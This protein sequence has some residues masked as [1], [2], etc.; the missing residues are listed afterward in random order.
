MTLIVNGEKQ[1]I[2]S[3]VENIIDLL[4]HNDV[5]SPDMVTVQLNGVFINKD[6]YPK[7]RLNENDEVDFLY[8]MGGEARN[9]RVF[10]K[11][12]ARGQ[13]IP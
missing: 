6:D 8:F 5:K 7:T 10:H 4:M 12:T 13:A 3:N 9:E 1:A 11:S 2:D